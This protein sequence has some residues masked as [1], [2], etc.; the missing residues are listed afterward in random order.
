[1]RAEPEDDDEFTLVTH[2]RRR[3]ND[4]NIYKE[5]GQ[6]QKLPKNHYPNNY[7]QQTHSSRLINVSFKSK[8][9]KSSI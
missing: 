9:T 6:Y 1:S 4:K 5:Y 8:S 7:K 2:R 3:N